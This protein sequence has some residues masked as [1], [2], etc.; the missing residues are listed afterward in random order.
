VQ[1]PPVWAQPV[2]T[3]VGRVAQR[4]QLEQRVQVLLA[5]QRLAWEQ[6]QL[7]ELV[8]KE[9]AVQQLAEQERQAHWQAQPLQVSEPGLREPLE[10]EPQ[11]ERGAPAD[12][13]L[14]QR[15]G[16][17]MSPMAGVVQAQA[18]QSAQDAAPGEAATHWQWALQ[19]LLQQELQEQVLQEQALQVAPDLA[20]VELALQVLVFAPGMVTAVQFRA[21]PVPAAVHWAPER[22]VIA[23]KAAE[24]PVQQY[25]RETPV[26]R[27]RPGLP[28]SG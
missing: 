26:A 9:L 7:A 1:V 22:P 21:G 2:Q 23:L 8:R 10:L 17:G 15:V 12:A 28:A 13:A 27:D 14:V 19:V 24:W 5:A 3:Q 20:A 25:L 16:L 11:A 18:E 6:V 4:V